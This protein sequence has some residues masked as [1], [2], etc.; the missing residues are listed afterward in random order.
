M[1]IGI[2]FA[3]GGVRG[4]AH[5]GIL[6]ALEENGIVADSYAGTS[7]GSIIATM[8]AL[9][10]SNADCLEMVKETSNRL[11]DVDYWGIIKNLPN[12]FSK[13][14][15]V[16]KG[17]EL[18]KFLDEHMGNGYLRHVKNDLIVASTNIDT[19]TQV[20]F[21]SVDFTK[22]DLRKIDDNIKAYDRYTSLP[23]SHIVYSSCAISGIFR[24]LPYDKMT[25]VDGSITNILPSNLLKLAG[26][27]KVIAIDLSQRN[28]SVGN[29]KGLFNILWQSA[30]VMMDQNGYLSL[31]NTEDAII[32]NPDV[33]SINILDF[34]R[35]QD[36]YDIG[37]EYGKQMI[38]YVKQQISQ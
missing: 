31:T 36:C 4:A 33:T 15:S 37:Y 29:V 6:Q 35:T 34:D 2:A 22:R 21:S 5:L 23:L 38:E 24:P 12:K 3:G 28:P 11:I 8:K 9:G 26:C 19:G 7:A 1:R 16:L 17:Y 25:L 13:L 30:S 18:Q 10:H 20:V 32:L 14:D 27:D